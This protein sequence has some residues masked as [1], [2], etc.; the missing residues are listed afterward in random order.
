MSLRALPWPVSR[1]VQHQP[2]AL[3]SVVPTATP[4]LISTRSTGSSTNIPGAATAPLPTSAW[5]RCSWRSWA[6]CWVSSVVEPKGAGA[7]WALA[8]GTV[9]LADWAAGASPWCRT[10]STHCA[11][12]PRMLSSVSHR[13]FDLHAEPSGETTG[14]KDFV[15]QPGCGRGGPRAG[16]GLDQRDCIRVAGAA[17]GMLDVA[18]RRRRH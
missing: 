17:Q 3:L 12:P 15:Q 5:A 16:T 10:P 14:G 7:S 11:S 4:S 9:C 13:S 18:Q 1:L 2:P 6:P 8:G